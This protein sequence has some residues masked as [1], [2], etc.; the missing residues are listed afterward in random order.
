MQNNL[1]LKH[2]SNGMACLLLTSITHQRLTR[3]T[4]PLIIHNLYTSNKIKST[5]GI[6]KLKLIKPI[7]NASFSTNL[8]ITCSKG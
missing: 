6:H 8:S 1:K 4:S 5:L 7:K 3:Q 2:V